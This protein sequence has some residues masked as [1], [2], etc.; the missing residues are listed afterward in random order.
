MCF[1]SECVW[2]C[3]HLVGV[4]GNSHI[5]IYDDFCVFGEDSAWSSGSLSF[6]SVFLKYKIYKLQILKYGNFLA[7]GIKVKHTL[8]LEQYWTVFRSV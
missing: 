6:V 5:I 3:Q 1:V 4:F 8:L 2:C 7:P